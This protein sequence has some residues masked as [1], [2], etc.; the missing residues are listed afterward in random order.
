MV[1]AEATMTAPDYVGAD[2]TRE[3]SE[4]GKGEMDKRIR[5]L[6]IIFVALDIFIYP[7]IFV[8]WVRFPNLWWGWSF[9]LIVNIFITVNFWRDQS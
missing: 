7:Y 6:E 8:N 4:K 3:I 2:M 9:L 1:E 5:L